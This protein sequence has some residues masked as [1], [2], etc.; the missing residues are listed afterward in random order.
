MA[1]DHDPTPTLSLTDARLDR[2][3][4]QVAAL[5]PERRAALGQ[6]LEVTDMDKPSEQLRAAIEASGLT[7]YRLAQDTGVS[8]DS[9]QRWLNGERSM[10]LE[11][12]DALCVALGLKLVAAGGRRPRKPRSEGA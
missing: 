10:K 11:T 7:A 3:A 2:L 8:V 4:A 6:W 9:I 1:P 12:F 5:A